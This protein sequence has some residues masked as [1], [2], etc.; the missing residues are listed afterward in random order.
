MRHPNITR[1][2][3]AAHARRLS[4]GEQFTLAELLIAKLAPILSEDSFRAVLESVEQETDSLWGKLKKPTEIE[5]LPPELVTQ[6]AWRSAG[7]RNF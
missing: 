2:H 4:L 3:D 1:Y 7:K 6:G 5:A